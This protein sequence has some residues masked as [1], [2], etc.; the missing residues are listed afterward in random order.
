MSSALHEVLGVKSVDNSKELV[1]IGAGGKVEIGAS[2]HLRLT[3]DLGVPG[4][5]GVWEN[6]ELCFMEMV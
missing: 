1:C 3:L 6:P 4:G 2:N 5:I